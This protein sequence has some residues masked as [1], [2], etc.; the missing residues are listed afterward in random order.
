MA[1]TTISAGDATKL[2]RKRRFNCIFCDCVFD[3]EGTDYDVVTDLQ[4]REQSG[5]E[6]SCTCPTCSKTAYSYA[7]RMGMIP[8]I[9]RIR[10]GTLPKTEYRPG[11]TFDPAGMVVV[12]VYDDYHEETLAADSCTTAPTTALTLSR[13][14][15]TVTHTASGKTVDIPIFVHNEVIIRPEL[16]QAAYVYSGSAQAVKVKGYDA[17]TMT[18][19]GDTSKT[20]VG[21]YAVKF[22]PKT[23][24]CWPDGTTAAI[25]L[26]WLIARAEPAAPTL[27]PAAVTLDATHTSVTFAVTRSGDG[28]VEVDSSDESVAVATVSGTTVT[29]KAPDAPKTG[30][31]KITVKVKEGT[32]YLAFTEGVVC[33]VTANFEAAEG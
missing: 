17:A 26:P 33:D 22:T 32:N 8:E 1:I 25:T 28:A 18:R 2:T 15:V 19:S 13:D 31:A 3:A 5:I 10:I 24:Y 9:K 12:A 20:S 6:A 7:G 30:E 4:L 29:V 11:Q 14:H 16:E 21:S 23:G 27:T